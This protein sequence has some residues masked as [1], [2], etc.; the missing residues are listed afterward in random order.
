MGKVKAR[1]RGVK[2]AR[3]CPADSELGLVLVSEIMDII[4]A[5]A[6]RINSSEVTQYNSNSSKTVHFRIQGF[7]THSNSSSLL[8]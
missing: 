5:G 2:R 6:R 1:S 4:L 3:R 7:G 8:S